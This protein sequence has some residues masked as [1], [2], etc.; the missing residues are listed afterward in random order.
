MRLSALCAPS[1][2]WAEAIYDR[3]SA[4]RWPEARLE[5]RLPNTRLVAI[6]FS[7]KGMENACFY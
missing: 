6:E 1:K 7:R 4:M 5:L 3:R 2:E